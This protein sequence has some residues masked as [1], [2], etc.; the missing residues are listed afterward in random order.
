MRSNFEKNWILPLE[1][2]FLVVFSYENLRAATKKGTVL[3]MKVL[4]AKSNFF[5]IG[6]HFASNAFGSFKNTPKSSEISFLSLRNAK[7]IILELKAK[8][9]FLVKSQSERLVFTAILR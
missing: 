5:K 1:P 3:K 9:S 6:P 2:S 4:E 7:F 8:K